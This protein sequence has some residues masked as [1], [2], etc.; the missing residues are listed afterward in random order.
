MTFNNDIWQDKIRKYISKK[1]SSNHNLSS[2]MLKQKIIQ[3]LIVKGFY[4]E[5]ILFILNEF[6]LEDDKAI[7]DKEYLKLKNKL[8]RK[9]SGEELEYQIKNHLYKK[10]FKL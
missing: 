3:D 10:G 5:D 7:Y 1:I 8:S 9:Y 4:K 6:E 2:Q